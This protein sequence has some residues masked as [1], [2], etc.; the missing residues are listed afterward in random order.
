MAIPMSD[1]ETKTKTITTLPVIGMTC[2]SCA[3]RVEKALTKVEGI[4][5]AAVNLATDNVTVTFEPSKTSLPA[6]AAS[7][8]DAGYTLLLPDAA[9]AAGG[10]DTHQQKAHVQLR[11]EFIIAISLAVPIMVLSMVGMTHW[12]MS[13]SPV[14]IDELNRLLLVAATVLMLLSGKRFFI[15][16]W[17]LAL[18]GGVD[19]NT[20][21]AVGTGA[22]Y[23]YSAAVVLFPGRFSASAGGGVV[24][25]DTA[26]TIIAFILLGVA[27]LMCLLL[28]A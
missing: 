27:G 5:S 23:L 13:V 16:A 22:A 26:S 8:Q 4:E 11:R 24:Y 18:H 7:V 15:A 25:F 21:V 17:R 9:A 19:M 1:N 14:S 2:A 6:L 10:G 12:F 3:G 20:L 28:L